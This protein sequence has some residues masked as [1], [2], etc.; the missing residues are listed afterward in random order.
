MNEEKISFLSAA[1]PKK[2]RAARKTIAAKPRFG[3]SGNSPDPTPPQKPYFKIKADPLCR[4][5]GCFRNAYGKIAFSF[6]ILTLALAAAVMYFGFSKMTIEI[7]PSQEKISGSASFEIISKESGRQVSSDQ[8]YGIVKQIPAEQAME[9]GASGEEVL[10]EEVIGRVTIVNNYVKNQP[11]V[12]TTR[13]LSPDGKLFRLKNTVNVPAGGKIEA[14]IYAD[15]AGA[16]M[17]KEP[18]KFTIP[19]LWAGIQDKIYAQSAESMQYRQ[20]VKRIIKQG[21]VDKA[22]NELKEKILD[23][24]KNQIKTSYGDYD[25]SILEI[26]SNSIAHEIDGK[27]GEE[28][29]KFTVKMK[30]MISIAVFSGD[31][32]YEKIKSKI[33]S[34]L[35]DDMEVLQFDKQAVSYVTENFDAERGSAAIR[36]EYSVKVIIKD[37]AKIIKKS[38]LAG[39][40]FDELKTYLSARPEIAWYKINFFPS[41]MKKAPNLADRIEV[42]IKKQKD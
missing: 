18:C 20:N 36:A 35:A 33:E 2:A 34:D 37:G 15:E 1:K 24:A 12:A 23:H 13:L 40:N 8:I 32:I 11:L 29:E 14:E 22:I 3:L 25:R 42:I 26:D 19:G 9:F 39:L 31:E 6:I 10:S 27:V 30:A 17:A 4:N 28:K 5:K 21:D 38:V 7:I 41:F 16:G